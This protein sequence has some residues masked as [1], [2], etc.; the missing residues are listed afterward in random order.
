MWKS[1]SVSFRDVFCS[2]G[3]VYLFFFA[4]A[5]DS[6][7][8]FLVGL[9]NVDAKLV[10]PLDGV[11]KVLIVKSVSLDHVNNNEYCWKNYDNAVYGPACNESCYDNLIG[12]GSSVVVGGRDGLGLH[13]ELFC[14]GEREE[15]CRSCQVENRHI[16]YLIL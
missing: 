13:K 5:L 7:L 8:V 4:L 12:I 14:W 16:F 10:H 2:F 9:V 1:D 6:A 11:F 3:N 15:K